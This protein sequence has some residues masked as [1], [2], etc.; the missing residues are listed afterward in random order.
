MDTEEEH[1]VGAKNH[2]GLPV[3]RQLLLAHH[4]LEVVNNHMANIIHIHSMP[5]GVYH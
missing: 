2:E 1:S 3:H 5:H 4:E